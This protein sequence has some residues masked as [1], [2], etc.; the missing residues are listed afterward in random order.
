MPGARPAG[1]L[2]VAQA[3]ADVAALALL[4]WSPEPARPAD[5]LTRVQAALAAKAAVEM[6]KG[7]LAEYAQLDPAEAL[8][9]LRA[10]SESKGCCLADSAQAL[11][12]R[13]LAPESVLAAL[14]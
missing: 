12:R 10:Y 1:D 2:R 14:R 13:T 4:H 11:V 7:M 6:A 9:L 8:Q 5:V 3:L